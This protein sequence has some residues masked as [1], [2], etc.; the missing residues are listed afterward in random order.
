MKR[1]CEVKLSKSSTALSATFLQ[2]NFRIVVISPSP[3][4][5]VQ[6][7]K[8]MS[9]VNGSFLLGTIGMSTEQVVQQ[10]HKRRYM[11]SFANVGA[12]FFARHVI[13]RQ[14]LLA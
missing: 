9:F 3:E 14:K 7:P 13:V 10:N 6:T 5:P 2:I 8:P 11:H 4:A 12:K 1:F